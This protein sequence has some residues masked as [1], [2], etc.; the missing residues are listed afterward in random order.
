[1]GGEDEARARCCCCCMSIVACGGTD[2]VGEDMGKSII[3]CGGTDEGGEDKARARHCCHHLSLLS[4][5]VWRDG[6][7]GEGESIVVLC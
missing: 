3:V 7:G 2:E 6:R 1:M 4:S 5:H